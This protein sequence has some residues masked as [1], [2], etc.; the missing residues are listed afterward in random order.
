MNGL[1]ALLDDDAVLYS[2][3]GGKV[4]AAPEPIVGRAKVA[5]FLIGVSKLAKPEEMIRFATINNSPGILRFLDGKLIQTTAFDIVDGQIAA[6]Y[7]VRNPDKLCHL[8]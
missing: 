6:I 3:G 8:D 5:R 4:A 1:L 2:D 7:V